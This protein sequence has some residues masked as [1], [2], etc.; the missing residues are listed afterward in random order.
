[1][2]RTLYLIL[3]S[4]LGIVFSYLLHAIIEIVY[5]GWAVKNDRPITWTMHFGIGPC[6]LPP[7]LQY[8]LLVLG[9]VGGWLLGFCRPSTRSA[10][11]GHSTR[12]IS[13]FMV[14]APL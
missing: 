10:C 3:S 2:K 9:A 14:E 11:S 12:P 4:V 6:A 8:G 7:V 13:C 1:M 5:L